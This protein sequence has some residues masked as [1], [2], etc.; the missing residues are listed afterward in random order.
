MLGHEYVEYNAVALR[1]VQ[2]FIDQHL[3]DAE[4]TPAG[5]AAAQHMSVRSLQRLFARHK[6][7]VAGWVRAQRLARCRS[8]LADPRLCQLPVQHIAARWGFT[9]AAHFSRSFRAAYGIT[10]NEFRRRCALQMTGGMASR[11]N[12]M[13]RTVN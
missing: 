13:A 10:P 2:H 7:T 11:V 1:S 12:S 4:L 8:D 9:A 3:A 5:I 6:L